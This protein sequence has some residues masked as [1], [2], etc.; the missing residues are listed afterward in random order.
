MKRLAA[1]F[2]IESLVNKA[3]ETSTVHK[4]LF[5]K[6]PDNSI[7]KALE[8]KLNPTSEN[9]TFTWCQINDALMS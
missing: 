8:N 1:A 6:F 7:I 3:I 5:K 9:D 2:S 4:Q